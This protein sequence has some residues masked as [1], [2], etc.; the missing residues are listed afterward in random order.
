M[1]ITSE[2]VI[3]LDATEALHIYRWV[4]ERSSYDSPRAVKELHD[5]L[6][7]TIGQL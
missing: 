2:V 3:T 1:D 6:G 4:D 5:V 7:H